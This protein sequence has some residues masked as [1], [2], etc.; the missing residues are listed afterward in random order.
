MDWMRTGF[1]PRKQALSLDIMAGFTKYDDLLSRLD[2]HKT[3]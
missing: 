3:G 1:S 2:K